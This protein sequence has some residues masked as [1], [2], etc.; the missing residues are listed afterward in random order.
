VKLTATD[1]N[2]AF[3]DA[4]EPSEP[5]LQSLIERITTSQYG[6]VERAQLETSAANVSE[7]CAA[8][9]VGYQPSGQ[10][11]VPVGAP[12]A[13]PLLLKGKPSAMSTPTDPP[14]CQPLPK[15]MFS[16]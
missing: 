5:V 14:F 9:Q 4:R 16:C 3:E 7:F 6:S 15:K 12:H 8:R 2:E 10:L 13:P 11:V 1:M